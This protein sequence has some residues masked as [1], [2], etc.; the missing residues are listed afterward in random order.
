MEKRNDREAQGA[1][2]RPA[3]TPLGTRNVLTVPDRPGYH[4]LWVSDSPSIRTT[5]ADYEAAGYIF[6][7]DKTKV[8]D[9]YANSGNTITSAVSRPGGRGVTLY[10]MEVLNEYYEDDL[11][12]QEEKISGNEEQ[13]FSPRSIEGGYGKTQKKLNKSQSSGDF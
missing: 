13:M 9:N 6:V 8:G 2:E 5:I 4:R 10:L 7:T 3:R 12:L 1:Q 11:R